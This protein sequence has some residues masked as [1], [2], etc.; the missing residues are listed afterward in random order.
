MIQNF[1]AIPVLA[2]MDLRIFVSRPKL[3]PISP[4]ELNERSKGL[5]RLA[6]VR[7]DQA[8]ARKFITGRFIIHP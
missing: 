1:A 8:I 7:S 2:D 4:G 6:P 3:T 5:C